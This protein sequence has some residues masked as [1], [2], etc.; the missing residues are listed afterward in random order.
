MLES[1]AEFLEYFLTKQ[2]GFKATGKDS[3]RQCRFCGRWFK[4]KQAVMAH[5]RRCNDYQ[6]GNLRTE[7]PPF[8]KSGYQRTPYP[9]VQGLNPPDPDANPIV[10]HEC[11]ECGFPEQS[12]RTGL[13]RNCG[14]RIF[15][16]ICS[17]PPWYY[18]RHCSEPARGNN[19]DSQCPCGGRKSWS[20]YTR[21]KLWHQVIGKECLA[22]GRFHSDT[23]PKRCWSCGE[24]NLLEHYS[25]PPYFYCDSCGKPAPGN[26][27]R[28]QC[29][30]YGFKDWTKS[31]TK[32]VEEPESEEEPAP[33]EKPK[34]AEELTKTELLAMLM[35]KMTEEE[36]TDT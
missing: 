18:C 5:L 26:N 12:E 32:P 1:P 16:R 23:A 29:D 14:S 33:E 24:P 9:L 6:E 4:N 36:E 13:C 7:G 11:A 30:C 28:M 19:P 10:E 21:R 22:C 8:E 15:R 34:L 27:Q 31:K 25:G 20:K 2:G 17:G 3:M 35:L